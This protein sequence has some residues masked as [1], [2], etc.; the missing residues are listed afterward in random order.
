MGEASFTI[1]D[2]VQAA[3]VW[4][5]TVRYYERRGLVAQP[6]RLL[7]ECEGHGRAPRRPIIAAIASGNG[8][9]AAS[10]GREGGH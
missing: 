4:V 5:K 1:G 6:G 7:H 3:G 9:A 10:V 2:V 8:D